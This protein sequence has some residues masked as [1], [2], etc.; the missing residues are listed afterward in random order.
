[1]CWSRV[2]TG[3]WN[4]DAI[5]GASEVRAWG[6]QVHSIT[7]RFERSTTATLAKVRAAH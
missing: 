7:F 3:D 1:M 6:G 2:V 4:V 5:V